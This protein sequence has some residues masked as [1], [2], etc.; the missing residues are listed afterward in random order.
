MNYR[1]WY[2]LA[3]F[4]DNSLES[5]LQ[6]KHELRKFEGRNHVLKV[7]IEHDPR[8]DGTIVIRDNAAGIHDADYDRAF[9][10]AEAPPDRSGLSEFGM[11]MKSAA[12][13]FARRWTVR[14]KALGEGVER[15]VTFDIQDIVD[16]QIESLEVEVI[17]SLRETHYT[18]VVLQG[19][20]KP[21]AGRTIGKVKD[22]L[23]GIYR[24]FSREGQ[25]QLFYD[26]EELAYSD[27]RILRAAWFKDPEGK[28]RLWRKDFELSF[29]SRKRVS[30]FAALRET[31][32]VSE[33]GFA[34]F[35]RN[36]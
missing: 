17:P 20:H 2:A 4:V 32:S 18:E 36:L 21:M 3:E 6:F 25:L 10:T 33:A 12:S 5:Y 8:D 29:G 35:R 14:T 26:G 27:P 30:G 15:T 16:H 28:T 11:G 22:H 19:L 34:I 9:R 1:P 23:T 31:A 13:W 24:I 7:E